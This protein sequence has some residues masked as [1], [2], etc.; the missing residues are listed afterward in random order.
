MKTLAAIKALGAGVTA[1]YHAVES[2][3]HSTEGEGTQAYEAARRF[4]SAGAD[5]TDAL[6]E[7]STDSGTKAWDANREFL[8]SNSPDSQPININVEGAGSVKPAFHGSDNS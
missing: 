1:L 2:A 5:F 8:A 3:K 4:K 6:G 7:L